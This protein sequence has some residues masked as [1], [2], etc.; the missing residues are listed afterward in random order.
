MMC[1]LV[2]RWDKCKNDCHEFKAQFLYPPR[3]DLTMEE[4]DNWC[5]STISNWKIDNPE[6]ADNYYFDKCPSWSW[7]YPYRVP[8]LFSDIYTNLT[9]FNIDVNN[10]ISFTKGTPYSPFEQ[11]ALILPPQSKNILPPSYDFLFQKYK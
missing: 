8:P 2:V 11:L 9:K 1:S 6:L 4:Y 3:L 10:D 7:Y 5:V